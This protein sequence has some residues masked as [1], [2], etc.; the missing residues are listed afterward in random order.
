MKERVAKER[1]ANGKNDK[2][3]IYVLL[4]IIIV[5]LIALT[6]YLIIFQIKVEKS[7]EKNFDDILA[8]FSEKDKLITANILSCGADFVC[9]DLFKLRNYACSVGLRPTCVDKFCR[10]T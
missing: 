9:D 2:K 8:N 5:Y 1:V 10:C 3:M 7:L 6:V 4:T